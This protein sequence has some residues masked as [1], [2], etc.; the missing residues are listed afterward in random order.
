MVT[1]RDTT[2]LKLLCFGAL[3]L[4]SLPALARDAGAPFGLPAG[5]ASS[6]PVPLF[7][8]NHRRRQCRS[9]ALLRT[10]AR[11]RRPSASLLLGLTELDLY[12]PHLSFVFGRADP[13]AGVAVI[14]LARLAPAG[15]GKS[16]APALLRQR[17]LKEAVHELG[18]LT[19]LS[20]CVDPGCVMRYSRDISDTDRKSPGFCPACATAAAFPR[21]RELM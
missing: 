13:M 5:V 20:H 19:G 6:L 4:S 10:L 18:H 15:G 21:P 9:A 2:V 14:S 17:L 11:Q 12:A 8:R 7:A 1:D 3:E 16:P